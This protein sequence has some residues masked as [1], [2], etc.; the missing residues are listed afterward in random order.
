MFY[1]T[2]ILRCSDNSY[3]T[4]ITNNLER[5]LIEHHKGLNPTCYTFNKRPVE[6]VYQ[7]NFL[8]PEAV[9]LKISGL[10]YPRALFHLS[11]TD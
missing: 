4:G 1:Y 5:R 11:M 8:N 6:L 9:L 10:S 3:Y 7:Q 2:Y